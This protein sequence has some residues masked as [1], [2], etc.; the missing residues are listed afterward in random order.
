M[1]SLDS[2]N[3]INSSERIYNVE[4]A[5]VFRK[6]KEKFGGLSNMAPGFPLIVNGIKILNSEALYQACRFPDLPELQKKILSEKS[7]MTAK[8][9]SKP[10]RDQSRNDWDLV[11]KDIMYWCLRVKLAQNFMSFGNLLESTFDKPIVEDS[12]KD[13]FWGA[14][15]ERNDKNILRGVNA[16]G[17]LLMK[18]REELFSLKKFDLLMVPSLKIRDFKLLGEKIEPIDER[19]NFINSLQNHWNIKQPNTKIK[20]KKEVENQTYY[21]I[22]D[23]QQTLHKN[24]IISNFLLKKSNLLINFGTVY[25][26]MFHNSPTNESLNEISPL[27]PLVA[28]NSLNSTIINMRSNVKILNTLN[29]STNE[30]LTMGLS[31]NESLLGMRILN[32]DENVS[33]KKRKSKS[34][35]SKNTESKNKKKN[36]TAIPLFHQ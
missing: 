36:S 26:P 13:T 33:D 31:S 6:T 10:Y 27:K 14:M 5:C 21:D 19:Q 18:L 22:I 29:L 30:S 1:K 35:S 16:L 3:K 20:S 2:N 28:Y 7:P 24:I 9:V 8:M 17:R 32:H 23:K 12:T 25:P 11:R 4:H 15:R 34:K